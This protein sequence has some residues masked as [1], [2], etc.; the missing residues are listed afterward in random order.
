MHPPTTPETRTRPTPRRN[1]GPQL[2][3]GWRVLLLEVAREFLRG[4]ERGRPVRTFMDLAVRLSPRCLLFAPVT[5]AL[6]G[7]T[8]RWMSLLLVGLVVLMMVLAAVERW[9]VL[10]RLARVRRLARLHGPGRPNEPR[11]AP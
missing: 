10:P 2:D 9:W 7:R 4:A 8:G 3:D 5:A 1:A 6:G 11:P